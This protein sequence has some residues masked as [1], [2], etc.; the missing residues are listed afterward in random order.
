MRYDTLYFATPTLICGGINA[1]ARFLAATSRLFDRV[2]HAQPTIAGLTLD[3][4]FFMIGVLILWY[5]VGR[6]LDN[7]QLG[8]SAWSIT[9]QL[10]AG[11][12]L[13]L[14]GSL[15][16]Y[17][18]LQGFLTP[19]RW[20]NQIGNIAQSLLFML[21]SLVFLAVPA[22]K[23]A[24][25][26]RLRPAWVLI[27]APAVT[28]QFAGEMPN[29]TVLIYLTFPEILPSC[30]PGVVAW[31]LESKWRVRPFCCMCVIALNRVA[32]TCEA[33]PGL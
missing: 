6:A 26:L 20:N 12:P 19:S 31:W 3:Y 13:A 7:R 10:L 14:L 5:L 1:P 21:W 8:R 4:V 9:K 28:D 27:N 16:F 22:L 25:R 23:I 15:F 2:D 33:I 30:H 29:F 11:G 18:G 32:G 17:N 24:Q